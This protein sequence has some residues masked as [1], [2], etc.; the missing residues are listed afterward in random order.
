VSAR[1]LSVEN[2]ANSWSFCTRICSERASGCGRNVLGAG[3][4]RSERRRGEAGPRLPGRE[5][6]AGVELA[7]AG[8]AAVVGGVDGHEIGP[9]ERRGDV[10]GMPPM[11]SN[12]RS[13]DVAIEGACGVAEAEVRVEVL[14][15]DGDRRRRRNV[16]RRGAEGRE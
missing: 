10:G 2:P 1:Q 8:R 4:R 13:V 6:D 9:A 16:H 14:L 7:A 3:A 5:R 15:A 11:Y 12:W